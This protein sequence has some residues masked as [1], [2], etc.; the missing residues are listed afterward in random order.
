MSKAVHELSEAECL[1]YFGTVRVGIELILDEELE[2][3]ER[4]KKLK[5]PKRVSEHFARRLVPRRT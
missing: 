5:R 4:D 2:R 3:T 1:E